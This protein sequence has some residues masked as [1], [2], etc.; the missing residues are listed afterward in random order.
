[1]IWR[2]EHGNVDIEEPELELCSQAFKL[3]LVVLI[4]Q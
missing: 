2:N 4:P 3:P 1:M